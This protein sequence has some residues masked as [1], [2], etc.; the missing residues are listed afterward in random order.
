LSILNTELS[1]ET[2]AMTSDVGGNHLPE[3]L[4]GLC[5]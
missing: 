2:F 1:G 3:S 5:R 4:S